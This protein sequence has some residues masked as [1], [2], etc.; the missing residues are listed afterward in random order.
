MVMRWRSLP[1]A[2]AAFIALG[3]PSALAASHS[4][5]PPDAATQVRAVGDYR[6][7]P[8]DVLDIQVDQV[9]ELSKTF[10]VDTGGHL[11][12]PLVG[13]IQASGRTP[14]ELSDDIAQDLKKKY[15]KDPR[16]LV[17]LK[18][19]QGQRVTVDGAVNKPGVYPLAGPTTLLQAVSLGG[20]PDQHFANIHRVA[21]F[22]TVDGQ[23]KPVFYDLAKV[24]SGKDQDPPVYGNDIVVVDTSGAKSFMQNFQGALGPLGVLLRPW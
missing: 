11:L 5:P 14:A 20:G 23:R 16:V 21:I 6:I 24:R 7:G 12:L 19:A 3:A 18:E 10:Q 13:Q 9:P 17:G 1:L 4:P 15:M 2:A 22:R 8:Q